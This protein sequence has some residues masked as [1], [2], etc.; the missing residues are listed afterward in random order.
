MTVPTITLNNNVQIP[1]LGMGVFKM[2][3]H[4]Q[5]LKAFKW[6]LD[7]GYRHF[8]TAA[9][10]GNEKWLGEA[11][12]KSGID[13]HELFITSKLWP[14]EFDDPKQ[15]FENSLKRLGL[16]YLD[17]YLIHWPA[18]GYQQAW[19]AMEKLYQAQ[20]I[21]A[22]GVS[23]FMIKHLEQLQQVSQVTPAVDQIELHPYLQRPKL[24]QYLQQHNI[25]VEAWGPLGQGRNGVFDEPVLQ[26]LAAKYHKSVAQVILRWHLQRQAIIFPKS[27]HQ[28]RLQQ[29]FDIFDFELSSA[30]MQAIARLDKNQPNGSDPNS[31]EF[32]AQTKS[33]P[34]IN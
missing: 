23:N 6:A 22:I 12:K 16:D 21:R 30:D 10:Y 17:L 14:A 28:Q 18:P 9:I 13:R 2:K 26:D 1:Q 27:V 5:F 11:I 34:V 31:D 32:L 20:K 25:A 24:L 19:Q 3:D 15:A 33:R 7:I 29:N 4:E 8:D